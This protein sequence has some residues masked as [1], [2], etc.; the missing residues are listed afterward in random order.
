MN[1]KNNYLLGISGRRGS[2]KDT[3]AQLVHFCDLKIQ[4]PGYWGEK[5]FDFFL[6]GEHTW[7]SSWET[8]FFAKKLKEIAAMLTGHKDQYSQ[9]GKTT[10]LSEWGMTVGEIQQKLGTDGIRNGLHDQAWI[11][12]CFAGTK[13][14]QN[15]IITDM[16]F[17]NEMEAIK[18]RGG[19]TIRID[20]DPKN[21]Q[22]DGTRDDNHPSETSLDDADFDFHI[23]NNGTLKDL[24]EKVKLVLNIVPAYSQELFPKTIIF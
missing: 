21:Q 22:G 9:A 3:F 2:G 24:E 12:A 13:E 8:H 19:I 20:G 17:P 11:L 18:S 16:R 14:A 15:T 4:Y 6:N 5:T 1:T 7:K 10:F 23:I